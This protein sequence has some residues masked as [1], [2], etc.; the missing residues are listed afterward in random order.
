PIERV[1]DWAARG[2]RVLLFAH[3]PE[4]ASL[5]GADGEPRLP[6]MLTPLGLLNLSDELRPEAAETVARLGEAGVALKVISGDSPETV[7]ALAVQVGLPAEA[8]A[9][10][11]PELEQQDD[12]QLARTALDYTI[13][14]RVTPAQKAR[15][16]NALRAQGHY[17]AMTGDGINDV[18]ALKQ[19]NLAVA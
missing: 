10:S 11:G 12:A 16:V 9:V 1:R 5:T 13:F 18:L 4:P 6:P 19:A 15:L 3:G 14:G 17:V 7:A 2:L 8:K